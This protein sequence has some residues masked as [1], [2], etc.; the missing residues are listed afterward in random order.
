MI[1][2]LN[3]DQAHFV[4]I[5][6]KAARSQRDETLRKAKEEDL[7]DVRAARAEHNPTATLGFAPLRADSAQTAALQDAIA[8]CHGAPARSSTR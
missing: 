3:A 2:E 7:V 5:L 1:K 8:S 6:A 4:A